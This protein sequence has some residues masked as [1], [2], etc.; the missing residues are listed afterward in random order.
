[1]SKLLDKE[2]WWCKLNRE[3]GRVCDE[4]KENKKLPK[5]KIFDGMKESLKG[6]C[7]GVVNTSIQVI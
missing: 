1:M 4:N 6:Q 5:L 3:G 2:M 7:A